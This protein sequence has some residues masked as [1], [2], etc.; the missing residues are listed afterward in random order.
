MPFERLRLSHFGTVGSQPGA[1]GFCASWSLIFFCAFRFV[2]STPFL[3]I[4]PVFL[5]PITFQFLNA[6]D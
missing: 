2:Y 4:V 6:N 1:V 5:R 3:P